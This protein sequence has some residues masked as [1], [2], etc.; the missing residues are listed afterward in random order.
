M[1]RTL[2]LSTASTSSEITPTGVVL[3]YSLSINPWSHVLTLYCNVRSTSSSRPSLPTPWSGRS[4][5]SSSLRSSGDCESTKT[6]RL[7]L[8]EAI[9]LRADSSS[10][11]R[12]WGMIKPRTACSSWSRLVSFTLHDSSRGF[13]L[14]S[15]SSDALFVFSPLDAIL[16]GDRDVI[17]MK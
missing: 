17:V 10:A 15:S 6:G 14:T 3:A 5:L 4:S 12:M 2:V 7:E 11:A 1:Q 16:R 9:D 13:R 8:A